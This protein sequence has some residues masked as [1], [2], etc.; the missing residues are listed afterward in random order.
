MPRKSESTPTR[1]DDAPPSFEVAFA[2]LQTIVQ[3]LE[4]GGLDLERALALFDR[5]N[6]VAATADQLLNAAELRI[7]RLPPE[8][9]STLS[10]PA[11]DTDSASTL[12]APAADTDSAAP[13]SDPGPGTPTPARSTDP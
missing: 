10:N 7:T 4:D 11:A 9:A 8:S 3:Q 6:R 12:S 1:S 2:E 13:P 5:G